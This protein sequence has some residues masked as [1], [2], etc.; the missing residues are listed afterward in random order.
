MSCSPTSISRSYSSC[1]PRDN[2]IKR[3]IRSSLTDQNHLPTKSAIWNKG[4]CHKEPIA[5]QSN[6]CELLNAWDNVATKS[7]LGLVLQVIKWEGRLARRGE[8]R[9]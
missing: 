6:R 7:K 5:T 1:L 8:T 2:L 3:T 9:G 4:K